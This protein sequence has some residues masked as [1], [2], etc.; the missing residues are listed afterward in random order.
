VLAG[1]LPFFLRAATKLRNQ[2]APASQVFAGKRVL[3]P[4]TLG[5]SMRALDSALYRRFT[6]PT[7]FDGDTGIP[8]VPHH[9]RPRLSEISRLRN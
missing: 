4:Y 9:K 5:E 6:A 8:W 3:G 1:F 7:I 2:L